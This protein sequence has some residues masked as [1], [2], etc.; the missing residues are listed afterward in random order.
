M[1]KIFAT[2]LK[3]KT[4]E[5]FHGMIRQNILYRTGPGLVPDLFPEYADRLWLLKSIKG[6]NSPHVTSLDEF[7]VVKVVVFEYGV[8]KD[9]PNDAIE[10]YK[11]MTSGK[12]RQFPE[13]SKALYYS[14]ELSRDHTRPLLPAD[15]LTLEQIYK[16]VFLTEKNQKK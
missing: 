5:G 8:I 6:Y 11:F 12:F 7:E 9:F 4:L 13:D 10:F 15:G 14:V 3:H 16:N 2:V 1:K